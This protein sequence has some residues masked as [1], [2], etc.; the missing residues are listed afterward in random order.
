MHV[1]PQRLIAILVPITSLTLASA[2]AAA[3]A[4]VV[5]SE[6]GGCRFASSTGLNACTGVIGA[7]NDEFVELYNSTAVAVD[8]SGWSIQRRSSAGAATCWATLPA[9]RSIAGH[10]FYLVGGIGYEAGHYVG[11]VAADTVTSSTSITGGSESL[12]LYASSG[13]S[14]LANVVDSVSIGSITD[15]FAGLRLP[16]L[17]LT[18]IADGTSIE[19]KACADSTADANPQTGMFAPS[20]GH[21]QQGN[22]RNT[23]ASNAD[24]IA[25][26]SANPQ[27]AVSPPETPSSA[28]AASAVPLL[29]DWGAAGLALSMSVL[30]MRLLRRRAAAGD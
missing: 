24:W 12:V 10:G 21:S 17:A 27:S 28:C 4:G 8:V 11:A 30:G 23:G 26:T 14:N 19:R 16:P 1:R 25:R 29:V 13:C 18:S 20:G 6:Y 22:G 9:N 5:I 3:A 7:G 15:A 2:A